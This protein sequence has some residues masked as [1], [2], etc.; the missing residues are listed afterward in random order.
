MPFYDYCWL[1]LTA[2]RKVRQKQAYL[3]MAL[4]QVTICSNQHDVIIALNWKSSFTKLDNLRKVGF[5]ECQ[6]Q[7][8]KLGWVPSKKRSYIIFGYVTYVIVNSGLALNPV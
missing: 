5:D 8:L 2:L 1:L 3:G 4:R 6:T 7:L